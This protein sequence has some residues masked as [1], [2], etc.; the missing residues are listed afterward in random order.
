CPRSSR[1]FRG[2][3]AILDKMAQYF[4]QDSGEQHVY[5][6]HGLGG[7][8]KTQIGL[9][10]FK[11][12]LSKSYVDCYLCS[13]TDKFF[14]DASTA[15]TI[16]MGLKTIAT[17]KSIGNSPK[18]VVQRLT[19]TQEDWLL[20]FD[21]ADDPKI[22]LNSFL[23]QCNHGNIIITSRNPGLCVYAGSNSLVTD[24][25]GED[26]VALLLKSSAQQSTSTNEL[27]A[28]EIALC[29]LPLAIVQ[30]GAFIAESG[31]LDS[32]LALYLKNRA[33]LLRGKPAQTHDDYAWTV[34]TTWQMSFEQLSQ[35]AMMLLHLCSFLHWDGISEEIF[36]WAAGY[37]FRSCTLSREKLREPL[38]FLSQ[39]L[40]PD[41]EWDSLQFIKL[42][43][44][45]KA[46]SLINF[47]PERKVFSIHPLVHSWCQD[48]LTD[49]GPYQFIIGAILSMSIED[50]PSEHKQLACLKLISHVDSLMHGNRQL[51]TDFGVQ[52]G[53]I[54]Y[55]AG[56]YEEAH[57]AQAVALENRTNL[58]GVDHLDT[59]DA[60][61]WLAMTFGAL[62]QFKKAEALKVVVLE[63]RIQLLGEDHQQ[64]LWAMHNLAVTYDNLEQFNKAEELKIVVL[65]K[66]KRLQGNNHPDTLQAIHSLAVTYDNLGE[67]NKAEKLHL[68]VLEVRR[69]LLG[70]DHLH[71]LSTMRN[72][73]AIYVKLDQFQKAEEFL[74]VALEKR[75]MLLGDDHPDARGVMEDLAITYYHLG[76]WQKAEQLQVVVL[77]K[78]RN[79]SGDRHPDTLLAMR[80]L[81]STYHDL[82]KL[83]EEQ[84]L[85]KLVED[86]EAIS[87]GCIG[88]K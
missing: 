46:Y 47:D 20:F 31:A 44:E 37:K 7:A 50:I 27:V 82:G 34:Y 32:Y 26:A 41:G 18:E 17:M 9:K 13:F 45:I 88:S 10:F 56:R 11:N 53:A 39:F 5:V 69:K 58:H 2:R 28:V 14:L 80:K 85:Q 81:A 76:Q 16:E 86:N 87:E 60:M 52:Y 72:L 1:I 84:E 21:N 51:A 71:T 55:Y 22:N 73:G 77:E 63:K 29:Y 79:L 78:H 61:H 59:L 33:N 74:V 42:T 70:D 40:G 48:T 35:P 19:T 3:R 68:G 12:R 24:M 30:A 49:Q 75:R 66:R 38:G 67:F 54:Y 8:G 6:L 4:A 65:E 15:Q 64:T 23:P 83:T 62:G 36:S 43:N 57:K 25:E